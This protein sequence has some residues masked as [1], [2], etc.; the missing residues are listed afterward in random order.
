MDKEL[1][2]VTFQDI[3][4]DEAEKKGKYTD[5]FRV[6]SALI[7]LDKLDMASL[8]AKDGQKV[9]VEN[10]VGRIVVAAKTSDDDPHPGLAF[11][12]RSPWSNQLIGDAV[13]DINTLGFKKISAKISP[14]EEN[15]T[16]VSEILQRMRN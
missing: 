12:I 3:F 11:M 2:I 1:N 8:G 5:E 9:L 16:Q 4:Q 14:T 10:D 13:C 15:L 6:A 7:I